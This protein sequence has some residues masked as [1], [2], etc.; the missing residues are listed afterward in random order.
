MFT[1]TRNAATA[2]A[3]ESA[4][5]ATLSTKSKPPVQNN[6]PD[7]EIFGGKKGNSRYGF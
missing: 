2:A 4:V 6:I 3:G 1:T 5:A 7:T